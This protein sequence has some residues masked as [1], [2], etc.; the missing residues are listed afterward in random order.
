MYKLLISAQ[1]TVDLMLTF[2]ALPA[3]T[4]RAVDVSMRYVELGVGCDDAHAGL[5]SFYRGFTNAMGTVSQLRHA[6]VPV[7]REIKRLAQLI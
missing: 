6:T 7:N 4:G 1:Y 5:L 2:Y 3:Q